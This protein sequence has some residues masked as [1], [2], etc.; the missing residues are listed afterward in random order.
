MTKFQAATLFTQVATL[1][2]QVA[3]YMRLERL[4]FHRYN[5]ML[6]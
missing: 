1:F 5:H 6:A 4:Y 3:M 2:T